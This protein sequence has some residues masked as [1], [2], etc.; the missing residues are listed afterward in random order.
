MAAQTSVERDQEFADV[1]PAQYAHDVVGTVP[2]RTRAGGAR[3]IAGRVQ[4]RSGAA[5]E[6]PHDPCPAGEFVETGKSVVPS[7]GGE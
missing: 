5:L 2:L 6:P 1:S 7:R 4:A 3:G